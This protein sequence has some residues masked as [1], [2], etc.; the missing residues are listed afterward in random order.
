MKTRKKI[1]VVDSEI[2]IL[3]VISMKLREGNYKVIATQDGLDALDLAQVEKPDLIICACRVYRLSGLELCKQLHSIPTTQ[4]IPKLL[5][6]SR[7]YG[8]DPE[9]ID[10]AGID[11]VL[12]KPFSPRHLKEEVD[13]MLGTVRAATA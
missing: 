2:Q 10:A 1:L 9:R 5:L 4:K 7:G 3:H 13:G 12:N 11:H 8:L 6:T